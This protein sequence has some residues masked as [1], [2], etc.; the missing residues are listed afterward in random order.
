VN[1]RV[2]LTGAG[3]FAGS[4]ALEHLLVKTDWPIVATDSFRHKGKTDRINEILEAHPGERSRVTIITH[5]L[6]APFSAQMAHRIGRIDY[7]ISYASDSH[8]NRSIIEPVSFIQNNVALILS[9]LEYAREA[10]PLSVII[11]ST[12]EVYGPELDGV[13]YAEWSPV[14]PSNPY[15]ASKAAQEAIA[16]SYWRTFAVPVIIVNCMN[17]IG[18]RQD[19]EKFVP[20]VIKAC[21]RGEEIVIHG[22][23][24][25]VGTRHYLHARNLADG[26]LFLLNGSSPAMHH[27]HVPSYDVQSADRPDR[28]NIASADK[29]DNLSLAKSIAEIVG[30]PLKWRMEDFGTSRP[31]HDA[32]YGLDS[33]KIAA[34]G[35][36]PP[37][38]FT[39]SLEKTVQWTLAHPVWLEP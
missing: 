31:G 26:V 33:A 13:P 36:T 5:D 20:K 35:W 11:I 4:H 16:I 27:D 25:E 9:V 19:V 21:Q 1:T 18:E 7:I 38:P 30:L 3:G 24:G 29:V 8:V 12:D 28:Y 17:M 14:L 23:H 37:I 34:L 22:R 32:H 10:Q 39:A 6:T 2:L 15:S